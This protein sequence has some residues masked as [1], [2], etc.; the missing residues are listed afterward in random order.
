MGDDP[1]YVLDVSGLNTSEPAFSE[2]AESSSA[3]RLRWI[4]MRFECCGVY[5]RI[6]RNR[7]GTAYVGFCPGCQRQV[8][9]R[10]G[11]GGTNSR[12]FRAT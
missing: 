9:I 6:Y 5:A 7:N 11:P 1:D 12:F 4:G 3:G 10:I 8:R 2:A